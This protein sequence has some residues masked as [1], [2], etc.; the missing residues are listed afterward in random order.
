MLLFGSR[1][2]PEVQA[3]F[4]MFNPFVAALEITLDKSLASDLPS[5]F[6]NKLWVNNLFI[7]IALTVIL[8]AIS[9]IKVHILFKEQK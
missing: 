6:G 4:L 5:I 2:S 9:A 7:S 8:L 3:W 1:V